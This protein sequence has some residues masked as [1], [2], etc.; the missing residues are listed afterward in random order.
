MNPEIFNQSAVFTSNDDYLSHALFFTNGA[1]W[2]SDRTAMSHHFTSAKLKNLFHY[3]KGVTKNFLDNVEEVN[4]ENQP[5]DM[6]PLFKA[7]GIDCISKF[8]FAIDVNSF[9]DK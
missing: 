3:F 5:I 9:R 2:K 6:K 7:F 4:K 1:K 8:I